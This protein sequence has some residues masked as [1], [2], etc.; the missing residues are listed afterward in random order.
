MRD[1]AL[2]RRLPARVARAGARAH[3]RRPP[4][5]ERAAGAIPKA[6]R[7]RPIARSTTTSA[8][9]SRATCAAR[10]PLSKVQYDKKLHVVRNA[11]GTHTAGLARAGQQAQGQARDPRRQPVQAG[12]GAVPEDDR[13]ARAGAPEGAR[14]RP[15]VLFALHA[16]GARLP[17]ARARRAAVADGAGAPAP[18]TG[19]RRLSIRGASSSPRVLRAP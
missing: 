10:R 9:S 1:A 2:P 8:S 4:R 15:G 6:T 18:Q 19:P 11:L 16:H 17:P 7:S 13:R 5:R 3:R 12:A 14:A